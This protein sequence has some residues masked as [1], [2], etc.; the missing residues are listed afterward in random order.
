MELSCEGDTK[1]DFRHA[2]RFAGEY[3][4]LFVFIKKYHGMYHLVLL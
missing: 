3:V 4:L 1:V 2:K